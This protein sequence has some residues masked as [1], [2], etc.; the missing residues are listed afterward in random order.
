MKQGS[1]LYQYT[2]TFSEDK[3][4]K[5][6]SFYFA[7]VL[8]YQGWDWL[9]ATNRK[10][11]ALRSYVHIYKCRWGI[12]TTFRVQDEVEI[13]TKSKDMKVRYFLFI[14]EVLIY[15]LWQFFRTG[16]SFSAFVLSVHL[17]LLT[18]ILIGAVLETLGV[19]AKDTKPIVRSVR[20]HLG[21]PK[22]LVLG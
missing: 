2:S 15:N 20:E 10:L 18:E 19:E 13:K 22:A 9:F 1:G 11:E 12:E 4:K 14:V 7:V 17:I 16:L 5:E 6:I 21:I 3:T 8:E